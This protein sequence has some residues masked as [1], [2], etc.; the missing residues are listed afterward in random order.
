MFL[1]K[2]KF[3]ILDVYQNYSQSCSSILC[4]SPPGLICVS[5]VCICP[6]DYYW[7]SS[8]PN[9]PK[10]YCGNRNSRIYFIE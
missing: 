1:F 9:D 4:N 8:N 3:V 7:N 10:G 5:N 2:I 6:T